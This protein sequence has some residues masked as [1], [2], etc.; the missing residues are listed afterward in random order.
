MPAGFRVNHGDV[1]GPQ[2]NLPAFPVSNKILGVQPDRLENLNDLLAPK[3][4]M[5]TSAGIGPSDSTRTITQ[6]IVFYSRLLASLIPNDRIE[7]CR[8]RCANCSKNWI[9]R[10]V[11]TATLSTSRIRR[12]TSPPARREWA[13]AANP[14]PE[15]AK[16]AETEPQAAVHSGDWVA[17]TLI[18][19]H[20]RKPAWSSQT[21]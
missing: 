15:K 1:A 11:S 3:H 12:I 8:I 6:L 5:E 14:A 7:G 16:A 21:C 18:S 20:A 19:S 2:S 4:T 13:L 9:W 10:G 17:P